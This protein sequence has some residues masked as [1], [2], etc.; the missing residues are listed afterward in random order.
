MLYVRRTFLVHKWSIPANKLSFQNQGLTPL[1]D[2]IRITV[3][4]KDMNNKQPKFEG[5]D[6][7]LS[8]SYRSSVPENELPGQRVITIKAV[9]PDHESPSNVASGNYWNG[10]AKTLSLWK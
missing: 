5:L 9:D 1:S 3:Q 8:N 2:E 4:V 7:T 6:P 10:F